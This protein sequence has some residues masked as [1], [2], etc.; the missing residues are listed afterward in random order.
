VPSQATRKFLTATFR[1]TFCS[2][3]RKKKPC[4]KR[5]R[6]RKKEDS[7]VDQGEGKRTAAA[8]GQQK[9]YF[10]FLVKPYGVESGKKKTKKVLRAVRRIGDIFLAEKS[11]V[12]AGFCSSLLILLG[13]DRRQG[14]GDSLSRRRKIY[15]CW[16][17]TEIAGDRPVLKGGEGRENAY[18]EKKG[19]G[20]PRQH[21]SNPPPCEK[22]GSCSMKSPS[23]T[24]P[25]NLR[26]FGL[27]SSL[28]RCSSEGG[29]VQRKELL[30]VR[31]NCGKT[32][33]LGEGKSNVAR[34]KGR[35]SPG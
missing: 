15:F 8:E 12:A 14:K 10:P 5:H 21:G 1:S 26:C 19:G 35:L 33:L 2:Q 17:E 23:T 16:G 31:E 34:Q 28:A 22:E 24:S 7:P 25:E 11:A 18:A 27:K 6:G 30:R 32:C 3:N 9:L 4:M 20:R 13:C 29:E